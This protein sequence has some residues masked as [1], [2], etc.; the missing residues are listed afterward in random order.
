MNP[1]CSLADIELAES[2]WVEEG[3]DPET[4]KECVAFMKKE[5]ETFLA[6]VAEAQRKHVAWLKD[7][8]PTEP[9]LVVIDG[10]VQWVDFPA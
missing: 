5:R 6:E 4:V 9:R 8:P 10:L 1:C 7:N 2:K 3:G